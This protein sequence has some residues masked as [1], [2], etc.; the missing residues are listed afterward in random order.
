MEQ[1]Q[2]TG[3]GGGETLR[4]RLAAK[5]PNGS[6]VTS[7]PRLRVNDTDDADGGGGGSTAMTSSSSSATRHASSSSDSGGGGCF[8]VMPL[9]PRPPP[10]PSTAGA[11]ATLNH[12]RGGCRPSQCWTG[13]SR[14]QSSSS[15]S[16]SSAA[17]TLPLA[18]SYTRYAVPDDGV[19]GRSSAPSAMAG[20]TSGCC[21]G[22]PFD[23]EASGRSY[24]RSAVPSR[25]STMSPTP[26]N[27]G[28]SGTATTPRSMMSTSA[29]ADQAPTTTMATTRGT[30]RQ[31]KMPLL[32]SS[33]AA[34]PSLYSMDEECAD[35]LQDGDGQSAAGVNSACCCSG[36]CRGCCRDAEM[37]D[38][39]T[40]SKRRHQWRR[41]CMRKLKTFFL[42]CVPMF[43]VVSAS[44]LW[45]YECREVCQKQLSF[46]TSPPAN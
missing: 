26:P 1:H 41:C 21:G 18:H 23:A 39:A 19:M 30:S 29:F 36:C 4:S 35:Q 42:V 13:R 11:S 43:G 20:S 38:S 31:R 17:K 8:T 10:P 27:G 46:I 25:T 16:S 9:L 33:S 14:Q 28:L 6:A 7:P 44:L 12:H 40:R 15:S 2:M 24:H 45:F 34:A 5:T 3:G 32:S 22:L 37:T